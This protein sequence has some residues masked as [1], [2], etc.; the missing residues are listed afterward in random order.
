LARNPAFRGAPACGSF[1]FGIAGA[2]ETVPAGSAAPCRACR[3]PAHGT[4]YAA[5]A[6]NYAGTGLRTGAGRGVKLYCLA[7]RI[8]CVCFFFLHFAVLCVRFC[9]ARYCMIGS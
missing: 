9:R 4:F 8:V 7:E 6:C 3:A 1:Q 2:Q 5:R